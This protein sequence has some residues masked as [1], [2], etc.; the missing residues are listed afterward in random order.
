[1]T[2]GYTLGQFNP[3]INPL[4]LIP[5]V[6]FGNPIPNSA[7]I[8]YDGRTPLRGADTLI[9]FS[10]NISYTL[11]SH[12]F[13]AGVYA[14]RARNY[15]G[16]TSTF[17]GAFSFTNDA[18]NPL[19]TGFQYANAL[20][21][22]FTQ[23]SESD[24]RPSGEGRQSL[25]DFFVQDSWKATRRLSFEFGA[26]FG[27]YNQWYQDTKNAA[28]FSLERYAGSRAPLFYQPACAVVVAPTATCSPA[29]RRAR[30]PV[31]GDP[32]PAPLIGAL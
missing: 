11:G 17:A 32:R 29:N 8:S 24:T 25:F 10:D 2:Y 22:N 31:A 13:K 6:S 16:A 5:T 3:Q 19:N 1:A 26:R 21:G 30:H 12:S 28:A 23:Y 18:N 20:L 9:S 7:A 4:G 14:E 15:E 27:W